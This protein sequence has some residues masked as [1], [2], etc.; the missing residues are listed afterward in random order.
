MTTYGAIAAAPVDTSKGIGRRLAGSVTIVGTFAMVAMGV[1]HMS[2]QQSSLRSAFT[3]AEDVDLTPEVVQDDQL[4]D[5]ETIS[6]VKESAMDFPSVLQHTAGYELAGKPWGGITLSDRGNF[7][8]LFPSNPDYDYKKN[9]KAMYDGYDAALIKCQTDPDACS[10]DD[11]ELS[12]KLGGDYDAV[13]GCIESCVDYR[14]RA[15]YDPK[16]PDFDPTV[17]DLPVLAAMVRTPD[18][19]KSCINPDHDCTQG[20][21]ITCENGCY[22]CITECGA[23][24]LFINISSCE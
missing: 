7:G 9:Y 4:D 3:V 16:R 11:F 6:C 21:N 15:Y 12:C 17:C 5:K 1:T 14:F 10:Y 22:D 13:L 19:M 18:L 8:E 24:S 23:E 2:S 20:G